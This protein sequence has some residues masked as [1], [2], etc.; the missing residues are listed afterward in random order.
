MNEVFNFLKENQTFYI[1]TV[2]DGKPRVRPF[3]FIME[4]DGKIYFRTNNTK[5]VYKQLK[6]NADFEITATSAKYEWIRL[7]GK[8]VFDSNLAAKTKTFEVAPF[9]ADMYKTP[10]NPIFEVFYIQDGE[11]TTYS[12]KEEPKKIK[13]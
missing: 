10:D 9:L 4:Y 12:M 8:T 13:L 11:A 3:G 6:Q 7:K 5:N 2:E 1:V